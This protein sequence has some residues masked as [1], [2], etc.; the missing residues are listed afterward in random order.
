MAAALLLGGQCDDVGN[1]LLER[2]IGAAVAGDGDDGDDVAMVGL[3]RV[4]AAG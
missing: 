2:R 1:Q 4:P 3:D